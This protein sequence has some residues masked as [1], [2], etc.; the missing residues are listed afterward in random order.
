MIILRG[1]VYTK[2]EHGIIGSFTG[3]VF[4]AELD[5]SGGKSKLR[6]IVDDRTVGRTPDRGIAFMN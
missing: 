6:F 1:V 5:A 2:R 3:Q 4:Y